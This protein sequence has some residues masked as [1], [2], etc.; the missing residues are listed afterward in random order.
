M[1]A[2][3]RNFGEYLFLVDA[4]STAQGFALDSKT[5]S[6]MHVS[7]ATYSCSYLLHLTEVEDNISTSETRAEK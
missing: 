6:W 2:R 3:V 4:L 5:K 7:Q 1:D